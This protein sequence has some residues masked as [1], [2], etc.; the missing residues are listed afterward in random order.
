MDKVRSWLLVRGW[1]DVFELGLFFGVMGLA[2]LWMVR[3]LLRRGNRRT[4]TAEGLRIEQARR[5]QAHHD[6][7]SYGATALHNSPTHGIDPRP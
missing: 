2:V 5:E 6:R 4:E 3:I 1:G 7:I